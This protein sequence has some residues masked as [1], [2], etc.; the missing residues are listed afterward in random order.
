MDTGDLALV[1]FPRWAAAAGQLVVD[2][3][4]DVGAELSAAAV[5]AG[6]LAAVV[7]ATG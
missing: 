6:G 2:A 1:F 7:A 4:M 3:A 5:V